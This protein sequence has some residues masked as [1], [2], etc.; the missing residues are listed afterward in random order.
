MSARTR[1]RTAIALTVAVTAGAATLLTGCAATATAGGTVSAGGAPSSS[2]SA[3][4]SQAPQAPSQAPSGAPGGSGGSGSGGSGASG[5]GGSGSGGG[6][7][8]NGTSARNGLTISNGTTQ[9]LMNGTSV[10]FGV[11]V[12][13]LAWS[14]NG[15]KA[16]F[17][18]GNGNLDVSNPDGSGRV[19]VARA[20]S[21]DNWSHP[22]WRVTP[23]MT[24]Y[25]QAARNDIF[26]AS[27]KGGVTTLK[28]VSA[29]AVNGSPTV[30]S[31]NAENGPGVTPLPQTGNTW[32]SVG[33]KAGTAAYANTGNGDIY[34][35]DDN[36]RQQGS[37]MTA[38]S[39]PAMDTAGDAVVFVRSVGGH[40]H[41]FLERLDSVS[42]T[43]RDLTPNAT[44]DY[45]EPTWSPDG[46]TIAARTPD[47]IATVPSNGSAAPHRVS[48]VTGL[49][50]YRG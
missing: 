40:D 29:T 8:L 37:M 46:G 19:V 7:V 20:A 34:L 28:S 25:D 47:G 21:G 14:P 42:R 38:G 45:T 5:S 50:A 12:R 6:A 24:D 41:L 31:L 2:S 44:T 43:A 49:P 3:G 26:F 36:I 1:T 22:S 4:A 27:S 48:S 30:L 32:P 35:R 15:S 16:A 11:V 10:D 18:D 23:A 39:E 9:V 33:G 17:I 13:D